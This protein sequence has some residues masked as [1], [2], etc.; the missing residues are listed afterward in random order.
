MKILMLLD[1]EFPPDIRVEN[2]AQSLIDA[3]HEVHILSYNFGS[4]TASEVFKGIHIHRF[5]IARQLAKKMLGLLNQLPLYRWIW[6]WQVIKMFKAQSFDAVHI[7]DLP[8]C[9]LIANIK[10]RH[11]VMVIADMH[12]NYPYLVAEQPYMNS[13]FGHLLL[14]KKIWFSKEKAWLENA[15]HIVCVAEEMKSRLAKVLSSTDNI[16]VVPNTLNF[17]TFIASQKPLPE[18]KNRFENRFVVSFIGGIDAVRGIDYLL[19]AAFEIG[20]KIPE[21]LILLVGEGNTLESLRKKASQLKLDDR[22]VFEGFKPSTYMQAYI[23]AS[24]ICVIPHVRSEQTDNSSPNKLFQY[25]YFSKPVISSNC[26]SLEKL[27]LEENCGLIFN[28]RDS[29]HLALQITK[30]Y[31]DSDLRKRLGSNGNK[32]V[33]CKY[34]WESTSVGLLELY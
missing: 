30:L 5:T 34:N 13:L 33:M 9:C 11:K 17:K 1:T 25:M 22:V 7:H 4:K 29:H 18:L 20:D 12:E 15:D 31:K 26:K 32:S 21:L 16:K 6:T 10:R 8:L 19:D 24:H 14:S 3:G 23:E 27:I 28:D 2:E